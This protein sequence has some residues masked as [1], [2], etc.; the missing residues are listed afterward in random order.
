[1]RC[2][3][4]SFVFF[5]YNNKKKKEKYGFLLQH[6]AP[7]VCCSFPGVLYYMARTP[8]KQLI[9]QNRNSLH[10]LEKKNAITLANYTSFITYLLLMIYNSWILNREAKVGP[11]ARHWG[12][13]PVPAACSFHKRHRR[14][15]TG[16]CSSCVPVT[17]WIGHGMRMTDTSE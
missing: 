6:K 12:R 17:L 11:N 8:P 16:G 13:F 14:G 3:W 9:F 2:T 1:M 10:K 7:G 15:G 4:F 5:L